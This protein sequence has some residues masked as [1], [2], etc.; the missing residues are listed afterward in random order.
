ML[1]RMRRTVFSHDHLARRDRTD[2]AAFC[3]R[4]SLQAP[5]RENTLI[6]ESDRGEVVNKLEDN[7]F[8]DLPLLLAVPRAAQLLGNS[9]A[10]AYRLVA[11]GELPVRRLGGRVYVVIAGLRELVAS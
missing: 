11:S 10:A 9:R 1:R 3:R 8:D 2:T 7:A 6:N 4:C 5:Q